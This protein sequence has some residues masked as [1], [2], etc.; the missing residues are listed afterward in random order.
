M[1]SVSGPRYGG[2]AQH[3]PGRLARA[4]AAAVLILSAATVTD[5]QTTPASFPPLLNSYITT[6]V[7]L[8]RP[9]R[10]ALLAG[11]PV[12]S[13][14]DAVPE[15]EVAIF[16]AVWID[17]APDTCVRLIKDI[18]RFERGG[19]F[20]VT[21]RISDPPQLVDF[22]LLTLPD[23]DIEALKACRVSDCDI[24]LSEQALERIIGV[25]PRRP[26]EQC[27]QARP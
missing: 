25:H 26:V 23:Q 7:R 3:P 12:T 19:A 21:K 20:R 6:S 11:E 10:E 5:S 22:A 8:T 4:I 14:L 24:K 13:L 2:A 16:G 27:R 9:A 18:E 1:T 15:T 17:A